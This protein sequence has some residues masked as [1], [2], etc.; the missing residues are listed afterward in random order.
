[1][2]LSEQRTDWRVDACLFVAIHAVS[3]DLDCKITSASVYVLL[4]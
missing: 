3:D 4:G 1:M 2:S